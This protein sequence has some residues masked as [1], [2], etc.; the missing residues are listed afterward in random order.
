VDL[1]FSL[2]FISFCTI[3]TIERDEE[4]EREGSGVVY[5]ESIKRE[6]KTRP[7][8]ECRCDERLKTTGEEST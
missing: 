8:H 2:R 1:F 4:R 6:V 5:Y 3:N 7:I